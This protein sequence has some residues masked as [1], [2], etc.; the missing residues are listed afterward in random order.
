[1]HLSISFITIKKASFDG[2][3][4]HISDG[5]SK[6]MGRKAGYSGELDSCE[7]YSCLWTSGPR[8]E[9]TLCDRGYGSSRVVRREM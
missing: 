2:G 6:V 4:S 5:G 8:S 9:G 1:V 7:L 3:E